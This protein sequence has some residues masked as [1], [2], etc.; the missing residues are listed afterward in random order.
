MPVIGAHDLGS[1]SMML[2]N[3]S[4]TLSGPAA[5]PCITVLGIQSNGTITG[6]LSM[7]DSTVGGNIR[8]MD[9]GDV[10]NS[11][12]LSGIPGDSRQ[13]LLAQIAIVAA[14]LTHAR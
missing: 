10:W 8:D 13:T 7:D 12:W 2:N 14:I 5:R 3:I 6:C 11:E 1:N 9:I 4:L